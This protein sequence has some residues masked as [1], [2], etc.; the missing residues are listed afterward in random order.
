M[1]VL[2]CRPLAYV[3]S[4]LV[5]LLAAGSGANLLWSVYCSLLYSLLVVGVGT[6]APTV[7]QPLM[8]GS[9]IKCAVSICKDFVKSGG[10]YNK[11]LLL[12]AAQTC[13]W[14]EVASAA[15]LLIHSA[16]WCCHRLF[17]DLFR[18]RSVQDPI[19]F[20]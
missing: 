17:H 19:A 10:L 7:V 6:E 16:V 13:R 20:A 3:G 9:R 1:V 8:R 14:I 4:L 5:L 12:T 15:F 11:R 18:C 2:C